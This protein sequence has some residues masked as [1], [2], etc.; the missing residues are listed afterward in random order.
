MS[1]KELLAAWKNPMVRGKVDTPVGNVLTE[2]KEEEQYDLAAGTITLSSCA[3][4]SKPLGNK[5]Y[6]CTI[7][8]ECM[9]SCN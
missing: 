2:L 7:T 9:P 3:I 4:F 8:V 6:L 1:K 5:G